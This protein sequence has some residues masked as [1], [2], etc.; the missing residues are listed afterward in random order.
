M[1]HDWLSSNDLKFSQTFF[2][3]ILRP[4]V[5]K[6]MNLGSLVESSSKSRLTRS[7]N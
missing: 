2:V 4:F 7:L 3:K 5:M 1:M 6:V